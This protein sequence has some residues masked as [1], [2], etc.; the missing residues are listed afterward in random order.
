MRRSLS[1]VL[2]LAACSRAPSVE[3][4]VCASGV[5]IEAGLNHSMVI[6]A[7]GHVTIDGERYASEDDA[8]QALER[9][10]R[11]MHSDRRVAAQAGWAFAADEP[12][13]VCIDQATQY[14][15]ALTWLRTVRYHCAI[16]RTRIAVRGGSGD[17]R[18]CLAVDTEPPPQTGDG[19][20]IP[21]DPATAKSRARVDIYFMSSAVPWWNKSGH[22]PA[23]Y[24]RERPTP[25]D[26][27]DS[28]LSTWNEVRDKVLRVP[29]SD[30]D[31]GIDAA[32]P[33]NTPWRDVVA[34]LAEARALLDAEIEFY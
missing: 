24:V 2:L 30:R 13:V 15:T 17:D 3:L 26:Y 27:A 7:A 12:F 22:T 31:F 34:I 6:D 33:E 21:C 4:P 16:Y 11:S 23:W 29:A 5:E 25:C 18:R 19:P 10:A 8:T 20:M 32:L 28:E 9:V 1:L 14:A